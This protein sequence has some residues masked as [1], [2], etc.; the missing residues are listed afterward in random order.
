MSN[1]FSN[2]RGFTLLELMSVVVVMGLLVAFSLPAISHYLRSTRVAGASNT[3]LADLRYGRS[4]AN[5]QRSTY[6]IVFA[7]N[8]YT[9]SRVSPS[10]VVLRRTMQRGVTCAASDTAIF[11]P[12]GLTDPITVR[13]YAPRDTSTLVLGANGG[14]TRD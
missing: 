4:L 1:R 12:W 13:M 8:G 3:L 2:T 5:M 9:L 11:Y 7:S 14:V 10:N 6:R